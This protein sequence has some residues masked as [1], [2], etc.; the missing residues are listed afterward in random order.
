MA[1]PFDDDQI[2]HILEGYQSGRYTED[3]I[4]RARK[5]GRINDAAWTG[6]FVPA[7]RQGASRRPSAAASQS[8]GQGAGPTVEEMQRAL[9]APQNLMLPPAQIQQGLGMLPLSVRGETFQG[10]QQGLLGQAANQPLTAGGGRFPAFPPELIQA[11]AL[12]GN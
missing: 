3:D 12:R 2:Q 8:G 9:L 10:I 7:F 11:L 1:Q 6:A 4:R 5:Q